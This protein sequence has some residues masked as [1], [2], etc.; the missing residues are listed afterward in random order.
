[1]SKQA[2]KERM[3]KPRKKRDVRKHHINVGTIGHIDHG[4]STVASAVNIALALAYSR[5]DVKQKIIESSHI[6]FSN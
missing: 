4:K 2:R 3:S 5:K 6:E 1:M